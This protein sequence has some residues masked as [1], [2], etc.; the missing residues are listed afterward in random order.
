[1]YIKSDKGTMTMRRIVNSPLRQPMPLRF[2][3]LAELLLAFGRISPL[4]FGG[5]YA[6]L[7]VIE[8]EV[9]DKRC[10]MSREELEEGMAVAATAPGGIGVN[11][12][13]FV[14]YRLEGWPGLV[15]A[16]IGIALPTFLIVLALGIG[17]TLFHHNP[18]VVSAFAGIHA[19][20]VAL[21]AYAGWKMMR[22]TLFDTATKVLFVLSG[23]LLLCG[24]HPALVIVL[25]MAAGPFVV[26]V[27]EIYG[28]RAACGRREA[29]RLRSTASPGVKPS[30]PAADY[31]F[32]D[33]I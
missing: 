27:K 5:G 33:G 9:V 25:G 30:L 22:A 21:I 24:V 17:F 4:T 28:K 20:I 32:G 14:G 7:P 3:R 11:A 10:W 29:E 13:A 8:R 15:A 19:A 23:T 6:M 31:Y 1:M 12:A 26:K 2:V 18:K 16:I